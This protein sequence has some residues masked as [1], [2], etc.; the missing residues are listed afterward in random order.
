M[1]TA[2]TETALSDV[3]PIPVVLVHGIWNRAEIFTRLKAYLEANGRTVYALSMTPCNGDAL[4]ES[5]AQQVAAFVDSKLAPGQPFDLLGFSMGGLVSRYYVQHLGG[6]DR[7]RT[8]VS[9]SAPHQGTLLALGSDRPGVR[10]MCPGSD[11]IKALNQHKDCLKTLRFFSFWTPFDLLILPPW[12]S[13]IG[14]GKE[15]RLMIP[16]HNRMIQDP[17]ALAAIAQ[18]P[19]IAFIHH[20]PVP[21][22]RILMFAKHRTRMGIV[23]KLQ[24]IM[25][26]IFQEKGAVLDPLTLEP[27]LWLLVKGQVF[28]FCPSQNRF[29]F[30]FCL[31]GET[32]MSWINSLLRRHRLGDD[33]G[34]KL[35]PAQI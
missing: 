27:M 30:F 15:Q 10:Q 26:R 32:K 23:L 13:S 19:L 17:L 5:L 8:F 28:L 24:Q 1:S 18:S 21:Y 4:L 7:V 22:L 20:S 25:K 29:P 14:I 31:E 16:S 33:V 34:N 2:T 11:F 12:S 6:L 35:M 9:V 3:S